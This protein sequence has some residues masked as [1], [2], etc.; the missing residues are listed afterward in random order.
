LGNYAGVKTV[1]NGGQEE[2]KPMSK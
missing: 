1:W 2:W